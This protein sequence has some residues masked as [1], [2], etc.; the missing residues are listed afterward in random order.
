MAKTAAVSKATA[1]RAASERDFAV[2]LMSH[3]VIPTFVLNPQGRVIIWNRACER[4]TGIDAGSVLGT[5]RHWAAFYEEPRECLAD[6]I[7]QGRFDE[8][9]TLYASYRVH[10]V[11][12]MSFLAENW[13]FLP[14]VGVRLYLA[15]DAGPIFDEAGELIAV[16]ETLRDMTD[17][18]EAQNMLETLANKDSLTGLV[19][20]R[21]FDAALEQSW[22]RCAREESSL[23]LLMIDVD[24]FKCY[25]DSCG[26]QQGDDCLRQV[27]HVLSG[28]VV[29][30]ND[31]VARYGG[32]EFMVILSAAEE[33]AEAIAQRMR[34]AVEAR[35]L[36]HPGS[37][38]S[39]HITISIGVAT[40]FP[41]QEKEPALL[42]AKADAALYEAKR[43]GRNRVVA[44]I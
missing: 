18:K 9:S 38:I 19:N 26:H 44:S 23:S 4:L 14:A 29:R 27:A 13:C 30:V 3:L 35:V 22:A 5:Q 8:I 39:S 32:E 40:V 28:G 33:G 21:G 25:N 7:V 10:E 11:S 2:R 34:A 16:V 1:A 36:P 41:D 24:Y 42:I 12:P 37:P 43:A 15:I 20:R 6:L 17:Y 31:I